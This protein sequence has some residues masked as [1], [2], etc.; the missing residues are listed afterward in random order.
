MEHSRANKGNKFK[1][2]SNTL[3]V[4]SPKPLYSL[5]NTKIIYT[6]ICK[7]ILQ[8]LPILNP[9]TYLTLIFP[10]LVVKNFP[11]PSG[12]KSQILVAAIPIS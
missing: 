11:N 1:K 4:S 10:Y 9:L 3:A 7:K 8:N 2:T 6:I 12:N 5:V